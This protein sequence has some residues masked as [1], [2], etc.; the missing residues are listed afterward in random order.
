MVSPRSVASLESACTGKRW[1]ETLLICSEW[2]K[3]EI[4]SGR[5]NWHRGLLRGCRCVTELRLCFAESHLH[6]KN[7]KIHVRRSFPRKYGVGDLLWIV[8]DCDGTDFGSQPG[9]VDQAKRLIYR[10][11]AMRDLQTMLMTHVGA[12]AT[13]QQV[14]HAFYLMCWLIPCTEERIELAPMLVSQLC[15]KEQGRSLEG[16][17]GVSACSVWTDVP[18]ILRTSVR[19]WNSSINMCSGSEEISVLSSSTF[20]GLDAF[21]TQLVS[22][23]PRMQKVHGSIL[24]VACATPALA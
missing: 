8:R 10:A 9:L 17:S 2:L 13:L 4:S 12:G 15:N 20:C 6:L 5:Q 11:K 18:S 21:L 22:M 1:E 14:Q 24:A 3:A 19:S 16:F 7:G 23:V